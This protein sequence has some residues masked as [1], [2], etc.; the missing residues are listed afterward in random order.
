MRPQVVVVKSEEDQVKEAGA[1]GKEGIIVIV[2]VTRHT[3][4]G[5]GGAEVIIMWNNYRVRMSRS[6]SVGKGGERGKG[7][8]YRRRL[9]R[10]MN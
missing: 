3:P 4:D 7:G 10:R 2:V 6:K 1:E 9:R 5:G 8:G